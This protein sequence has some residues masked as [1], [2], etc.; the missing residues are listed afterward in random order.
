M[1][2]TLKT[3]ADYFDAV[4]RGDKTFEVRVNDRGFQKGD[5][6]E[7]RRMRDQDGFTHT[8]DLSTPSLM[9]EVTYVYSGGPTLRDNG[10]VQAGHV[11]LGLADPRS[12]DEGTSHD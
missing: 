5:L 6:L 1:I 4:L 2:H 8:C 11:V 7:L 3:R 10:G 12:R 9:R